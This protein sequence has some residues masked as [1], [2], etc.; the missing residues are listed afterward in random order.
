[1]SMGWEAAHVGADLGDD[2]LSAEFAHA[3]NR[4]QQRGGSTKGL[5]LAVGLL[6]DLRDRGRKGVDL[7]EMDLQPEPV[8]AGVRPRSAA[9]SSA[10]EA[11]RAPV[12]QRAANL[13]GSLSPAIT[14][15]IMA[16]P[17]RPVTS[18]MTESSLMLASSRVL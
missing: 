16:R 3:R 10:E 18:E 4:A 2:G 14:A 8:V 6:I 5:E 15:S 12:S 17:D 9:C 7:L 11:L 13:A 1:M